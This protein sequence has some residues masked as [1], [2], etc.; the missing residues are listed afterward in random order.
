MSGA[1]ASLLP[2]G[3]LHLHHG[4]IDLIITAEGSGREVA[5]RAATSRFA[6]L[7]EELV[8]ELPEL[9]RPWREDRAFAGPVAR[10][11]E[12]A[13]RSFLPQ[14]ITP[15]AAVAGA[16]AD[17]ILAVMVEAAPLKRAI[18]NNGGDI[19]LSLGTS[20]SATFAIAGLPGSRITI[21]HDD[22]WRGLA[23]SGWRGRSHSFG[24][25]DHVTVLARTAAQADAAATMIANAVDLPGHRA[26][27]RMPAHTLS[28]DSDLGDR[29]V[30]TG[31]GLLTARETDTA[32]AAGLDRAERFIERGLCGAAL[33]ALNGETRHA[34]PALALIGPA[35]PSP[36]LNPTAPSPFLNPTAP[37]PFLNSTAP[38]I[39][40]A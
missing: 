3:R 16:V 22:P 32:L 18:V 10:A 12:A 24:I 40:H 9:R 28:P 37:S 25:A 1:Q 5:Y 31:V 23:T 34:G 33:L 35:A 7:L 14:F 29:L 30:T 13:T 6:G 21:H 20:E 27:T 2:D 26:V 4:P 11:M 36:F 39:L 38:E 19:A 8:A 17:E 15:M